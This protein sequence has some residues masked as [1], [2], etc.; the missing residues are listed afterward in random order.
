MP[1][2]AVVLDTDIGTD[3]DDVVALGL[4]LCCQ[5]IEL[6]GV[7]TVYVNAELR[8]RMVDAVLKVAG[9]ADV[10]VGA[11]VDLPL[12]R[13]DDLYWAGWEGVGLLEQE[14]GSHS[15]SGGGV[16]LLVN[17][18]LARPGEVTV[19][20]IGPLT[21]VALAVL[22]EPR[23]VSA[24]RR[25]VIMGGLVQRRFDQLSTP[26]SEHN[27]RCDPEAAH[28]VLTCGAPITLVPLDV[29]TQVRVRRDDLQRLEDKGPVA[30]LVADQ[31]GRY[32]RHM[33]RDWTNPHDPLAVAAIAQPELLRTH[34][35]HI[36]VET[37]GQYT[38]GQT[39]AT[40]HDSTDQQSASVDVALEVDAAGFEE[41]LL[42]TLTSGP[43]RK[44]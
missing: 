24:V 31:L 14:V 22:R 34:P 40:S 25:I 4:I 44:G 10:P 18:V 7:S 21:N 29:T 37:C 43:P 33:E 11:G 2:Q 17:T 19:L 15:P 32:L 41:W 13:R 38:R 39:V 20:A 12:L 27:I 26:Y 28:I 23:F 16:D 1:M 42:S 3:V 8:A 5:N 9:R 36:T 30:S 35:M 6:R